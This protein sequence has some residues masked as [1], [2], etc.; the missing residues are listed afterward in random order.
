M[1]KLVLLFA[2]LFIIVVAAQNVQAQTSSTAQDVSATAKIITPI[3]IEL[4]NS[5]LN[6]GTLVPSGTNGTVTVTSADART[7]SNVGFIEQED[8][9][10]AASF[11][12]T[13]EESYIFSITLPDDDEIELESNSN[14]MEVN[15]FSSS[16]PLANNSIGS[17]GTTF[18][19]GA[20]LSV[21][22]N[23]PAGTYT[24]EFDVTV[25]YE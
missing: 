10:N 6:F 1:K 3:N 23:Q 17:D 13:G 20:T 5:G 15:A 2:S 16:L 11:K 24:G 22:A 7:N 8:D 12:V 14:K 25:A 4:T 18:K 9:F 19:V 21:D